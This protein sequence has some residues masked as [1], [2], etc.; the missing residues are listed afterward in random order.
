M[1]LQPML[2]GALLALIAIVLVAYCGWAAVRAPRETRAMWAGRALMVL[3]LVGALTRPG[4]GAVPAA[5]ASTELD[6]VFVVDLSTSSSAED[7]NGV[8]PRL[9]GM[10]ADVA[11]LAEQHPGARFA[12]ITFDSEAVQRLPFTT[13]ASALAQG[14]RIL[15][16]QNPAYAS[17]SSTGAA[18]PLLKELLESAAAYDEERM[19]VVYYLGDG[20]QTAESEPES[21][22][23]SAELIHGGA[24]LGYGTERGGRMAVPGVTSG[25][26]YVR[27]RNGD[28]ARSRIDETGLQRIADELRID[29]QRRDAETEAQP[30]AVDPGRGFVTSGDTTTTFPL[31]WV[32]ALAVVAWMLVEAWRLVAVGGELRRAR[33]GLEW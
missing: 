32:L 1:I 33:R 10:R 26:A 2:P 28:E 25:E 6:V 11:R 3:A 8:E 31:Y 27:D 20:E 9:N 30:A 22:E 16:V 17:G 15:T 7:W 21:F 24:V 4:V 18:A 12:V 5:A 19:R 23:A 14:M 29:Y 13:D